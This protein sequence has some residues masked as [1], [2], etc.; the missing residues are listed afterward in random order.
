MPLFMLDG[1]SKISIGEGPFDLAGSQ[2]FLGM[3]LFATP[4]NV[5]DDLGDDLGTRYNF[6]K[7]VL[8]IYIKSSEESVFTFYS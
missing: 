3:F 6:P 4:T 2:A 7:H 5:F 1:D 8:S